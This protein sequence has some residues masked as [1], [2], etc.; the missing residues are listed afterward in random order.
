MRV[1][2][3]AS[4]NGGPPSPAEC[5][6]DFQCGDAEQL[7]PAAITTPWLTRS[8]SSIP[9]GSS[10]EGGRLAISALSKSR[11]GAA[12]NPAGILSGVD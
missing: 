10:T 11:S 7:S 12:R 5:L 1:G 9:V 4:A 2:R 3:P 6:G 8:S